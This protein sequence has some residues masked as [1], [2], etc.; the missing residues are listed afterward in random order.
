MPNYDKKIC[1]TKQ[2]ENEKEAH[3]VAR[4]SEKNSE[5]KHPMTTQ[6]L[7]SILKLNLNPMF[8]VHV[9]LVELPDQKLKYALC[10]VS[11]LKL[12]TRELKNN[13]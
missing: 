4:M 3:F 7:M 1:G 11:I 2:G 12:S 5:L 13:F 10:P 8:L 9:N 6:E